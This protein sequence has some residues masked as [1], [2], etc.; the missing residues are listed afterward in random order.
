MTVV[1]SGFL[2][3]RRSVHILPFFRSF[4][5]PWQRRSCSTHS[6][7]SHCDSR[8]V[9]FDRAA[10]QLLAGLRSI[11]GYPHDLALYLWRALVVPVCSYGVELY[12]WS[13]RE[14]E[15]IR[16]SELRSWRQLLGVGGRAPADAVL[17]LIGL[18]PLQVEWRV[19]RL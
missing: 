14:L 9:A 12:V 18:G 13:P 2:V 17:T 10:G 8:H 1:E 19:R 3:P 4:K 5:S 6:F 16:L 11:P 15:A 7:N